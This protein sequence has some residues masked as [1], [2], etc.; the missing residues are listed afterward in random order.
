MTSDVEQGVEQK[1]NGGD[2]GTT[3]TFSVVSED[4]SLMKDI[5]VDDCKIKDES[6]VPPQGE[7]KQS[8]PPPQEKA[9]SFTQRLV[10]FYCRYDFLILLILAVL[11]AKAYPPLGAELLAPNI[12]A[13]WIAVMYIFCKFFTFDVLCG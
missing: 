5:D 4:A 6:G 8:L 1:Q 10:A 12:S 11:L 3:T 9:K 7:T 13:T 2:V